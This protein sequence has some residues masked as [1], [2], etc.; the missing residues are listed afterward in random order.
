M[1]EPENVQ[2]TICIKE[3]RGIKKHKKIKKNSGITLIALVIT[4][5]V[6]IILAGV[7]ITMISGQDE[8]LTRAGKAK[9]ATEKAKEDERNLVVLLQTSHS[10][11]DSLDSTLSL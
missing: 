3:N 9:E 5:I 10:M 2:S 4:I 7:S 11:Q 8:I 6:L 1:G